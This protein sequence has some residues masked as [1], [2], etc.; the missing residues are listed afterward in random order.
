MH[1]RFAKP[2]DTLSA[3]LKAAVQPMLDS[4]DFNARFTP[5]QVATLK[6]ATG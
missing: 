4:A 2:F 3:P 5:E 6:A 1:P